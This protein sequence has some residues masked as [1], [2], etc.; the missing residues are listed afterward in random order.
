[1]NFNIKKGSDWPGQTTVRV[2]AISNI[3]GALGDNGQTYKEIMSVTPLIALVGKEKE[4]HP[5]IVHGC[6]S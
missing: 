3:H 4:A 2:F 5:T 6:G 1:M